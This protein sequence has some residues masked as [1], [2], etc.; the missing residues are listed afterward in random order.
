[1]S[2][3]RYLSPVGPL[4]FVE[5]SGVLVRVFFLRG[6][7]SVPG[8]GSGFAAVPD[9]LAV[10]EISPE[11]DPLARETIRQF[12]AYFTRRLTRFSLPIEARGTDFQRAVW[13]ALREIPY[14][15]TVSYADIARAVGNPK[16]TRAVGRANNGNPLA[17]VIPCHRVVGANGSLTGYSGGLE[18]KRYLLGLESEGRRLTMP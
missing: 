11:T 16:A 5:E 17:I 15:K 9:I 10:P 8:D 7:G 4:G 13:A 6:E 12:D 2:F 18:I 3:F 1:V 14:G